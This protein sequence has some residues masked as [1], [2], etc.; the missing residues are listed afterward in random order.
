MGA[1]QV[2]ARHGDMMAIQLYGQSPILNSLI[3]ARLATSYA[4]S[5]EYLYSFSSTTTSTTVFDG[6][7]DYSVNGTRRVHN[8]K[9]VPLIVFLSSKK[10]PH[11]TLPSITQA[12]HNVIDN[13]GDRLHAL[14]RTR[15]DTDLLISCSITQK[16]RGAGAR[17]SRRLE[18]N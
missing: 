3:T 14:W 1:T 11:I 7:I 5:C 4:I 12:S 17:H 15:S 8:H 13:G 6:S 10:H 2:V 16:R 18:P 9:Q